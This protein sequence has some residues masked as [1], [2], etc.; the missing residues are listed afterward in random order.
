MARQRPTVSSLPSH[1]PADAPG[2]EV[3]DAQVAQAHLKAMSEV[4]APLVRMMIARGVQYGP[5]ASML[6]ALYVDQAVTHFGIEGEAPNDSRVSV[7]TGVHRAEVKRLRALPHGPDEAPA[8]PSIWSRVM[9][10]WSS[11]HPYTDAQ[12]VPRPLPRLASGSSEA[13]FESLVRSIRRDVRPRTVLDEMLRVGAVSLD[14]RDHVHLHAGTAGLHRPA[15]DQA[16][17]MSLH[18]AHHAEAFTRRVLD[19][20]EHFSR[21]VYDSDLTEDDVSELRAR[22]RARVDEVLNTFNA[23]IT[24]RRQDNLQ[25]RPEGAVWHLSVGVFDYAEPAGPKAWL[26]AQAA[27]NAAHGDAKNTAENG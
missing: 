13:S 17:I 21:V 25:R 3:A 26:E 20:D 6:K 8:P 18:L 9:E 27:D 16:W 12:G 22:M 23:E 7:L 11:G 14:E 5:L 15:A 24:A 2:P 10:V 19:A 1:T 4:L